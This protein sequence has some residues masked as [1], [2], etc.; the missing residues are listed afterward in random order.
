MQITI[1]FSNPAIISLLAWMLLREAMGWL[2]IAGLLASML[3]VAA[4]AQPPMLFGTSDWSADHL[5]GEQK[6]KPD[7]LILV[8]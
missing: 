7:R 5:L 6:G 1:V 3:G 2:G 4:V 8:L